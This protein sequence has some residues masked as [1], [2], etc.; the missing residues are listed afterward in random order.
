[1]TGYDVRI[2]SLLDGL[3]PGEEGWEGQDEETDQ[4]GLN[5]AVPVISCLGNMTIKTAAIK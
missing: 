1:M 3:D 4:Q 2:I 5:M